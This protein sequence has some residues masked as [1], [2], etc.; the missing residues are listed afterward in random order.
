MFKKIRIIWKTNG[1]LFDE[2]MRTI[3]KEGERG[4]LIKIQLEMEK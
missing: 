4:A 1:R 3:A 2:E